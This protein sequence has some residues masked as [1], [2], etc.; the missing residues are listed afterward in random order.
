MKKAV[1]ASAVLA[2]LI[3]T[4]SIAA[5]VYKDDSSEIT[6]G[7]RAEARFNVSNNNEYDAAGLKT[8]SN[9]DDKTRARINISGNTQISDGLT[10][11]GTYENEVYT[12]GEPIFTRYLFAGIGTEIGNFSYGKQDTALVMIT[13]FTDTM[14]TFGADADGELAINAGKDK[15]GNNFAYEGEFSGLTIGANYVAGEDKDSDQYSLGAK[16]SFDF[17]LDLGVGYAGGKS[18][19]NDVNQV[20]LGA[21][22]SIADFTFGALY[23]IS[24]NDDNAIGDNDGYEISA[25][26]KFQQWTF[27]GVYNYA[28]TNDGDDDAV[29]NFALETVYKFNSNLRTYVGYKFEQIDDLDDQLQAGIRYDF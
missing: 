29:D 20:D 8:K 28:T 3:S 11:F 14:A 7:G 9:F 17:G 15:R 19:D 21:Q 26:Y 2:A 4:S 5:S 18:A 24:N 25:Q 10:G 12:S 16:Y 13:D 27:V 1:L 6:L 22:Y 23:E